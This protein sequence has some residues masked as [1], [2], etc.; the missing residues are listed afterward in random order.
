MKRYTALAAAL[1][2]CVYLAAPV[3]A[4]GS[5]DDLMVIKRAVKGGHAVE[6]G[7]AV[8]WL[9]I[10]VIDHNSRTETVK[11][12]LPISVAKL[13]A[14]CARQ[15]HV[16]TDKAEIDIAEALRDLEELS[17]MTLLEIVDDDATIKI[18]LE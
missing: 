13:L 14:H 5:E 12:T 10:L 9:K 2:V 3:F 17:P 11:I 6:S 4:G 1:A 16:H 18:W 7:R 8:K 15:R